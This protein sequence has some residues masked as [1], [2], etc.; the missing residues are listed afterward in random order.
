MLAI[1]YEDLALYPEYFINLIYDFIGTKEGLDA[2]KEKFIK[3]THTQVDKSAT[4]KTIPFKNTNKKDSDAWRYT[5]SRDSINVV[6]SWRKDLGTTEF[7]AIQNG[8][9]KD[10]F[11]DLGYQWINSTR[12]LFDS[13]S[14]E[15]GRGYEDRYNSSVF[16]PLEEKWYFENSFVEGSR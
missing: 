4:D 3:M 8:C 6:F 10:T 7:E 13:R 2:V 9:G 12:E 1:R 11:K 16:W 15:L 14:K 5:T